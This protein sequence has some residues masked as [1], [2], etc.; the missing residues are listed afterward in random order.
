MSLKQAVISEQPI[1]EGVYPLEHFPAEL[2]PE[3]PRPFSSH[4]IIQKIIYGERMNYKRGYGYWTPH[5][6][7]HGLFNV[8][9]FELLN[10]DR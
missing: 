7:K 4:S 3:Q 1:S 9:S 6:R 2:F 10:L 8:A 5:V